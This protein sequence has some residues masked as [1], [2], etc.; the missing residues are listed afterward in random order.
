MHGRNTTVCLIV[1]AAFLVSFTVAAMATVDGDREAVLQTVQM[2]LDGWR[3]ADASK[4]EM[5]LHPD[6]REVTLHL[7]DGKWDFGVEGRDR[8]IKTMARI[9]KGAWDDQLV[10]PQLH[11][12]GPIAVVWSHYK[13]T[14]R[15]TENGVAH[16]PTHCGVETFQLY[17]SE[18]GW[19][20]VNFADTHADSCP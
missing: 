15:Y 14:V 20:I 18:S 8:L 1:V 17:R 19:K 5:A 13:F 11:I 9:S 12:D 2:M 3:E 7:R 6:F 4:L 16:A 10:D